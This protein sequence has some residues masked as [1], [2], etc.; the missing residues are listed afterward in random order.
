[1]SC[2][3]L[4]RSYRTLLRESAGRPVAFV[5]LHGSRQ[6]LA[7]RMQS[8]AGHFMPASLLDTQFATLEEPAG[9]PLTV[10][11]DIEPPTQEV[12]RAALA[13]LVKL[14]APAGR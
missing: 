6:V 1:M 12:V 5:Y 2:S 11:M 9:E 3:A 8:R 10:A 4:K 13:A 14:D 7:D